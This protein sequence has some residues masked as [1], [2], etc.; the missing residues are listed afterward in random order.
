M[1]SNRDKTK[2]V[3]SKPKMRREAQ[4]LGVSAAVL[5]QAEQL[6]DSMVH[7]CAVEG[8]GSAVDQTVLMA[9]AA[10]FWATDGQLIFRY[11]VKDKYVTKPIVCSAVRAAFAPDRVES[12]WFEGVREGVVKWADGARGQI[13]IRYFAPRRTT[14]YAH[15]DPCFRNVGTRTSNGLVVL[16]APLPGLIWAGVNK[17]Y[18]IFATDCDSFTSK[19]RLYRAPLPNTYVN[20]SICW[21]ANGRP[22][23]SK[24][25]ALDAW[26]VFW[27]A[28]FNDHVVDGASHAHPKDVRATL[29][30]IAGREAYPLDDL[31]PATVK[32]A[33]LVDHVQVVCRA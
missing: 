33:N 11:R 12:P 30:E 16:E 26:R 18:A 6:A 29:A 10:L 27:Q 20:G 5:A 23:V 8:A 31:M 22:H 14:L 19:A 21:G 3:V 28:P 24:G 2:L 7:A 13:E 4:A 17:T 25:G 32:L 15:D 9:S 1:A